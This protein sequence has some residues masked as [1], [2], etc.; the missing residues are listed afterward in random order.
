[1]RVP[2]EAQPLECAFGD[3]SG[4]FMGFMVKQHGIKSNAEKINALFKI[5]SP[6]KPNM[7]AFWVSILI[8]L[9]LKLTNICFKTNNLLE[10]VDKVLNHS[11][12]SR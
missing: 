3:R 4:K 1:M 12:D 7:L 6:R 5:S 8:T 10:C 2:D 9:I 11:Q